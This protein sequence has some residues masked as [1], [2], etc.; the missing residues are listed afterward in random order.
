M[1]LVALVFMAIF[2]IFPASTVS[3]SQP[4]PAPIT[5]RDTPLPTATTDQAAPSSQTF[6][7]LKFRAT[8]QL[9][10]TGIVTV[11]GFLSLAL[12]AWVFRPSITSDIERVI[13]LF[14]VVIVVSASLILI[15]GGYS[16]EQ[17]APAFGL[18]GTIVGYILGSGTRRPTADSAQDKPTDAQPSPD[19]PKPQG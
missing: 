2:L 18:F 17:I 14:I 7:T 11:F 8:F 12:I 15:T 19:Q 10:L 3:H 5:V 6:E 1:K 9:V 13:R 4:A 16:N